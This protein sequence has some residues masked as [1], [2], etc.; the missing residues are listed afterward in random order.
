MRSGYSETHIIK[1]L[2]CLY[3]KP[4]GRGAL[5]KEMNLGESTVRTM[6]RRLNLKK[7]LRPTTRGQALSGKGKQI[8]ESVNRCVSYPVDP[9]IRSFTLHENNVAHLVRKPVK[10]MISAVDERDA[11]VRMGACGLVVL[12][13]RRELEVIGAGGAGI[14]VPDIIGDLLCPEKGNIVIITFASKK[15]VAEV[16]GL[17]IALELAGFELSV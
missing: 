2:R 15:S 17:G 9:D 3:R 12:V 6:L 1:L 7:L 5:A 10:E 13:Q 8:A 4:M 16:A 11:A 14:E